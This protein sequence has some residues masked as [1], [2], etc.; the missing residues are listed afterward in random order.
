MLPTKYLVLPV[1]LACLAG[2]L[3]GLGIATK[4]EDHLRAGCAVMIG[5]AASLALTI[6]YLATK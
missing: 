4:S 3:L 2:I 1:G 5:A 6:A